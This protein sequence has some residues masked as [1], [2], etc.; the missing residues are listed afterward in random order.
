ML[1][2]GIAYVL[3]CMYAGQNSQNKFLC[4]IV[5]KYEYLSLTMNYAY[6]VVYFTSNTHNS[7]F[8]GCT[9]SLSSHMMNVEGSQP[10]HFRCLSGAAVAATPDKQRNAEGAGPGLTT[11]RQP[12]APFKVYFALT[13]SVALLCDGSVDSGGGCV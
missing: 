8:P 7:H 13:R 12:T 1:L 3:C 10:L 5:Y 9:F 11:Y 2:P 6:F 4:I